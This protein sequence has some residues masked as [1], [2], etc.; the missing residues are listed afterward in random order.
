VCSPSSLSFFSSCLLKILFLFLEFFDDPLSFLF[1]GRY[2]CDFYS[3]SIVLEC[4]IRILQVKSS[5]PVQ[6]FIPQF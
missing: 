5:I 2:Y 1:K 6:Y 3:Y 4:W